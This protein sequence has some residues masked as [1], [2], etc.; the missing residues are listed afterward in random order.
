MIG[1]KGFGHQCSTGVC[2]SRRSDEVTVPDLRLVTESSVFMIMNPHIFAPGLDAL[3]RCSR[4]AKG[5]HRKKDDFVAHCRLQKYAKDSKPNLKRR[6]I[7]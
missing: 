5:G 2:S 6:E 1:G 7:I 3:E 4:G